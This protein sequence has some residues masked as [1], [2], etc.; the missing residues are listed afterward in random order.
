[1]IKRL[2]LMVTAAF[3]IATVVGA[4]AASAQSNPSAVGI[5]NFAFSAPEIS[6]SAGSTVTWTNGDGVQHTS[7]SADG[8]W[9]SGALNNG[10]TFS[11]TFNQAGDFAYACAIHPNMQGV[12]HVL[13]A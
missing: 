9:D 1:M 7:S 2:L 6:V 11:F 4:S 5:T 10:D 12:I 13:A 8:L 3:S